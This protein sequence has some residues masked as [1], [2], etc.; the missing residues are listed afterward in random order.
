MIAVSV[1]D[2]AGA[3]HG[4]LLAGDPE[5]QINTVST[6][7]R[8]AVEGVLFVP[9]VGEHFDGHDYIDAAYRKGAAACLC[10]GEPKTLLE[11]LCYISVEDTRLALKALAGW[12]RQKFSIPMIQVTGSVGKTTTK[13]MLAAVLS[14]RLRTLKTEGNLNNDIGV[15]RTLLRLMPEHQAAVIE[16][17]MNHAGEIRYLGEM[18]KPNIAVISNIGD[19]HI[20]FLGSREGI[21]QAKCEIL[22]NLQPDGLAVFNG[23]DPLLNTVEPSCR[24]LRCGY[25]AHCQV[26]VLD[27]ADRGV[28]GVFCR[29][30]TEKDCYAL[31]IPS[32][33][34]YM[35]Y[36][37]AFAVAVGEELGL[38][39]TEI[40]GGV[41]D[42]AP[43][44]A[45]MN[46]Q[47][48]AGERWLL[49][50]FYNANPQSMAAALKVL[51]RIECGKRIAVLGDMGELGD[52]REQA[53]RDIGH[54]VGLLGIDCL[55]AI[56]PMAKWMAEEA[57]DAGCPEVLWFAEKAEACPVIARCFEEGA[58]VLLKASR[59][60]G[61]FEQI[62]AYLTE[63]FKEEKHG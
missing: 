21:L 24:V 5:R 28:E 15:P 57:E 2:I 19:A 20:E 29:V 13:E 6:D 34:E 47:R 1:Q 45:R 10:A 9:L 23:N 40:E 22:E 4:R 56:G 18:V 54:L 14:V 55:I 51:V 41:R 49:N 11:G 33:G 60:S 7:S 17:G 50:D 58:A 61:R 43:A 3:V 39:R 16:T 53:H 30:Q 62:A 27:F 46:L 37:A 32:P 52:I 12:Y 36:P 38:S 31:E 25:G 42:Y 26:R 8:T 59:Y 63:E 48:L 35:V 44:G